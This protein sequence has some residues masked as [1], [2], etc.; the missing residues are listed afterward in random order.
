M[1]N[2]NPN[3]A[4]ISSYHTHIWGSFPFQ[5]SIHQYPT[6][7]SDVTQQ[8]H[9][10]P[11]SSVLVV[12]PVPLHHQASDL[13]EV[14]HVPQ[15]AISTVRIELQH[16][17]LVALDQVLKSMAALSKWPLI[18]RNLYECLRFIGV[19]GGCRGL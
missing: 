9:L 17:G 12:R 2:F 19:V 4:L 10:L 5:Y 15:K 1:I 16:R 6:H 3:I 18:I 11:V 14:L 8:P 13:S 7:S